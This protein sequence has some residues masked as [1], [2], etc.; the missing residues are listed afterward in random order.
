MASNA[1]VRINV[2]VDQE[3]K[4]KA[5]ALFDDLGLSM[6]SAINMFLKQAVRE[7]ALP[8]TP[9]VEPKRVDFD[10]LPAYSQERILAGVA[11]IEA[12]RVFTLDEMDAEFEKARTAWQ[13]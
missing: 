5:S 12:G 7:K 4:D 11:D 3:T 10:T 13:K 9:A 1:P 6:A 8:F 2:N